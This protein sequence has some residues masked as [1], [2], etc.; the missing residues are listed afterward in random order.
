LQVDMKF[1]F[2]MQ[3]EQNKNQ[4]N[5][6]DHTFSMNFQTP[7]N[8]Q[9]FYDSCHIIQEINITLDTKCLLSNLIQEASRLV[10]DIV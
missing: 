3:E 1:V 2:H 8:I 10:S 9:V 6:N 5:H 7:G 4:D